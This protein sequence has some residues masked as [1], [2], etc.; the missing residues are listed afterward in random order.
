MV[1]MI[2]LMLPIET[3]NNGVGSLEIPLKESSMLN[4]WFYLNEFNLSNARSMFEMWFL[5]HQIQCKILGF[6][7]LIKFHTQVK[8]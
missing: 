3:L 6:S 4:L 7:R 5:M 8:R 1:I 2:H